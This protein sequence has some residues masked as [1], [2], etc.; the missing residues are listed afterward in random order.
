MTQLINPPCSDCFGGTLI[1]GGGFGGKYTPALYTVCCILY[2]VYCILCAVYCVLCTVY[3]ILCTVCCVLYTVC[4]VLYT[5]YCLLCTVY[6]IASK[7][8][9]RGGCRLRCS[10]MSMKTSMRKVSLRRNQI[11]TPRERERMPEKGRE[12]ARERMRKASGEIFFYKIL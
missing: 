2:T 1:F 10:T 4:C 11:R 9:L 7:T 3:C 5:V 12:R 8:L 6:C